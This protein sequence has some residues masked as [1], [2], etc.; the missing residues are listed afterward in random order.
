VLVNF[1]QTRGRKEVKMKRFDLGKEVDLL[2]DGLFHPHEDSYT[3]DER[4][5]AEIEGIWITS[6]PDGNIRKGEATL[7]VW[8]K[9]ENGDW[10]PIWQD[11]SLDY[12]EDEVCIAGKWYPGYVVEE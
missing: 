11:W 8:H 10:S 9:W 5:Y 2:E 1:P 3:I 6:D 4:G 12:I 7:S